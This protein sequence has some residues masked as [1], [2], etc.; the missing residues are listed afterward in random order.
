MSF[1]WR[2]SPVPNR[3]DHSVNGGAVDDFTKPNPI[4][5]TNTNINAVGAY[6]GAGLGNKAILGYWL[7]APLALGLVVSVELL[8]EQLTPEAGLVGNA[9]PY[10]N[11]LVELNPV[12]SPGV[13][14]V[15]SFG[16]P[17]NILNLGVYST[18]APNRHRTIWTPTNFIQIVADKGAGLPNLGPPTPVAGPATIPVSEGTPQPANWNTHDYSIANILAAYPNARIVNGASGDSGLPKSTVTAGLMVALG[19]STNHLQNAVR[20]LD[21]KFNGVNI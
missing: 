20:V 21:F 9:L 14:S 16:D 8:I 7:A 4:L 6:N 1:P 15:F 2:T 12:G 18:P 17:Q 3:R 5:R 10:L 13:L 11:M 19:D